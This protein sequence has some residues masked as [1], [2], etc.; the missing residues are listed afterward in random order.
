MVDPVCM[1]L[2]EPSAEPACVVTDNGAPR[3]P[4]PG[5]AQVVSSPLLTM[6]SPQHAI[7][8]PQIHWRW[9]SNP[10]ASANVAAL[11]V[12]RHRLGIW[13]LLCIHLRTQ[14]GIPCPHCDSHLC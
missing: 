11:G 9:P 7:P 3:S 4:C 14:E 2:L 6:R 13:G 1:A 5:T 8:S 10:L 12:R